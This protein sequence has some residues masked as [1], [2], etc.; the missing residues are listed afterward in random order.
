MAKVKQRELSADER[1]VLEHLQVRLVTSPEDKARCDELIVKHQRI[2]RA[3]IWIDS[4]G[5]SGYGFPQLKHTV[6]L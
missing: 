3:A 5:D 2:T 6:Y 1:H 4:R